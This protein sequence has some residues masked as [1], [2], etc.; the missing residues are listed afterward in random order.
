MCG[1][2]GIVSSYSGHDALVSRMVAAL[3]HRGPDGSGILAF[4]GCTLGHTRLSI[5]D[6]ASGSQPMRDQTGEI[7]ISF[8]GEIYGYRTLREE[9]DYPYRTHS[10]TEVILAAHAAFGAGFVEKL[11]GMFAFALWNN[12]KGELLLARDRFGEKPLYYALGKNGELLF[13]SE[14]KAILATGLVDRA[15]DQESLAHYLQYLTTPVGRSI[16][17][18]IHEL[19]PAH[20][21]LWHDGAFSVKPY[22]ALPEPACEL[23]LS[24]AAERFR[25]LLQ[26]A[27]CSQL[28][29]DVEVGAFLSGGLDSTTVCLEAVKSVPALQTIS[30]GFARRNS[31]LPYAKAVATYAGYAPPRIGR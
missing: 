10:D 14:I 11:K 9:I 12:Q 25:E 24:D 15:I 18:N 26:K 21:L 6:I 23:T 28:V 4:P 13:A 5:I 1:I 16:Y 29:A 30:Y 2:A 17:R 27:V 8:N 3:H 20:Q 19:P 31:E 7:A 22:W